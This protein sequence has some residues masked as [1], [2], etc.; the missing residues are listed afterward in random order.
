MLK[1]FKYLLL[2]LILLNIIYAFV[3]AYFYPL[4]SIDAVG[5]WLLKAKFFYLSSSFPLEF[6][7]NISFVY[8]HPH[9]PLLLPFIISVFY[10]LLGGVK[11][12][13][14]IFI[15]PLTFI[16]I[17]F[18]LYKLLR[19]LDF[20]QILSLTFT[21]VYS[22][23]SPLLAQAGRKH[24]GEADIFILLT[25][26]LVVFIALK[27]F[28]NKHK[29]LGTFL[30]VLIIMIASQIKLEGIFLIVTLIFLP[31]T[32]KTKLIAGI[33]SLIPFLIWNFAAFYLRLP[34][35]F[36]FLIPPLKEISFRIFA[37]SGYVLFEMIKVNN[38]YIFWPVFVLSIILIKTKN[39]F[40]RK[41][42]I[43]SFLVISALYF[44]VYVFSSISP[45]GYVPSSIDRVLIQISPY[46]FLWFALL[47]KEIL[48]KRFSQ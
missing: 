33:I 36:G 25:N 26:L 18:I 15:Y 1:V 30:I 13:L 8:S 24:A 16:A 31:I 48:P 37:I 41:F 20:G 42:I 29:N 19:K 4:S 21:Y 32:R 2:F 47:I 23:F 27:I 39:D 40:L 46:F 12:Q 5:I 34:N 28:K 38:W 10:F 22:M 43:P 7:K 6:L 45:E 9:Y 44:G 3:G 17:L 14:I 35:D 11:E